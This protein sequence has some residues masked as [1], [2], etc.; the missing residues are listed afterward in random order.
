MSINKKMA[1]EWDGTDLP[2]VGTVCEFADYSG[3]YVSGTIVAHVMADGEPQAIIQSSTDWFGGGVYDF[4]PL[5]TPEQIAVDE[6]CEL[7]DEH[8]GAPKVSEHY[9]GLARA[10]V[11]AGYRKVEG[12]KK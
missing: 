4:R 2:P 3:E 9:L 8:Y 12:E 6:L 7:I 10:I 5:R 11:E 1:V